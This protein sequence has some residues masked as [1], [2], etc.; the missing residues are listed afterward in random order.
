VPADRVRQRCLDVLFDS[1][2][3]SHRLVHR[4]DANIIDRETA[5]P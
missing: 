2:L 4:I 1:A 3:L 5:E